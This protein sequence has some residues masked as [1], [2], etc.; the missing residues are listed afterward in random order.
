MCS[1]PVVDI[2]L[3]KVPFNKY[4]ILHIGT[5]ETYCGSF[6]LHIHYYEPNVYKYFEIILGPKN[7][8]LEFKFSFS[9]F[10]VNGTTKFGTIGPHQLIY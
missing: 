8:H 2:I 3:M 9:N 1:A 5:I 7:A 6:I 10:L 4:Y